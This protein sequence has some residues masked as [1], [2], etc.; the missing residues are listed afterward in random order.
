MG[1]LFC[2][3]AVMLIGFEVGCV[4]GR[5]WV[6]QAVMLIVAEVGCVWIGCG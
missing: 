3:Q 2:R 5:L 6:R 1:R 4:V